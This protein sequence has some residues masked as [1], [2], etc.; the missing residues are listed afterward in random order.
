[1]SKPRDSRSK[2]P[3]LTLSIVCAVLLI[4]TVAFGV[5]TLLMSRM[6]IAQAAPTPAPTT[7]P[8]TAPG[9]TEKPDDADRVVQGREVTVVSDLDF[10]YF[11]MS[12]TDAHGYTSLYSQIR[13]TDAKQAVT[14]YFDVSLYDDEGTLVSRWPT[15]SYLLP[16]QVTLFDSTLAEN[17]LDVASISVEQTGISLDPPATTGTVKMTEARGGDGGV[18]EGAFTSSLSAPDGN[19]QVAI[20]G[21]VD[22]EVFALCAD[23][24]EIPANDTFTARCTLEPTSRNTPEPI[25]DLPDDTEITA[26]YLLDIPR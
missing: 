10:G 24:V 9:A 7:S 1:M 6:T 19:A 20:V 3:L 23:Y 22:G 26:F 13:N 5:S 12:R 25:G 8:T 18:V 21:T 16:D 14:V 2:M 15:S 17:M 4:T 11:F